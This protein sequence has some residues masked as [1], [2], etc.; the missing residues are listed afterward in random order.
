METEPAGATETGSSP[1]TFRAVEYQASSISHPFALNGRISQG[2]IVSRKGLL[3]LLVGLISL[4]APAVL[5]ANE[6]VYVTASEALIRQVFAEMEIPYELS[7]DN[8][9]DPI[10]GFTS[11]SIT[12]TIIPHDPVG[13][14]GYSSLLFYAAW[15]TDTPFEFSKANEWNRQSRFGRVYVDDQGDPVIE[16]DLLLTG[17]VTRQTVKDYIEIF[18]DSALSFAATLRL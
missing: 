6:A 5:G 11:R 3:V 9:G 14:T 18:V 4:W 8:D 7:T 2:G 12:A 15:A 1:S 17:G 13:V 10:W 16:L